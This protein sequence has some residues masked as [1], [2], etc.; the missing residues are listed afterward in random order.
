MK[1]MMK[2]E[3]EIQEILVIIQLISYFYIMLCILGNSK[4]THICTQFCQLFCMVLKFG[5]F[6]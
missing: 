4:Y 6:L 3:E 1:F 5:L 2:L